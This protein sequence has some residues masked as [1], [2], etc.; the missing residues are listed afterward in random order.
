MT[1]QSVDDDR[2]G[3]LDAALTAVRARIER[4]CADAGRDQ[5]DITWSW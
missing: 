2:R 1:S 3:E 4:A 5:A